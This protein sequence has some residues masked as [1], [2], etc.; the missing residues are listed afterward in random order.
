MN[1][2]PVDYE[3]EYPEQGDEYGELTLMVLQS[4]SPT[5]QVVL[6]HFAIEE[7]S[8]KEIEEHT[9]IPKNT[10]GTHISRT[11]KEL[12]PLLEPYRS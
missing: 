1:T 5:Q 6:H 3:W 2:Q 7:M 12:R 10:V 8:Y 9:G 11:R 4:L